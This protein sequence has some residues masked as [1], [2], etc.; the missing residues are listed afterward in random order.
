MPSVYYPTRKKG[1]GTYKRGRNEPRRTLHW[2]L[3]RWTA[4]SSETSVRNYQSTPHNITEDGNTDQQSCGSVQMRPSVPCR[5]HGSP[6]LV[7]TINQTNSFY[8]FLPTKLFTLC[9]NTS[10]HL[11]FRFT[12]S[13]L[14]F[15]SNLFP[16]WQVLQLAAA[17]ECQFKRIF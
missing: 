4:N 7:P 17:K 3:G 9:C 6:S 1:K 16:A 14:V 12:D 13:N 15:A 2:E 10:L 11:P 8:I 5:L